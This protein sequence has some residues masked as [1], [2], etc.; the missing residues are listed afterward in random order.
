MPSFQMKLSVLIGCCLVWPFTQVGVA[1]PPDTV[2]REAAFR[3]TFAQVV[4]MV[5]KGDYAQA[6]P[7]LHRLRITVAQP[8]WPEIEGLAAQLAL[9]AGGT[10]RAGELIQPFAEKLKLQQ[11]DPRTY[12][13]LY[14]RGQLAIAV[15]NPWE[16]VGIFDFLV[17]NTTGEDHVFAAKGAAEAFVAMKNIPEARKALD[18][19]INHAQRKL[20]RAGSEDGGGDQSVNNDYDWLIDL[21]RRQRKEL[22][23]PKKQTK[24]EA[25]VLFEKAEKLRRIDAKYK[26]AHDVYQ[27]IINA[28][29]DTTYAQASKLFAIECSLL[30]GIATEMI[31]KE[32]VAFVEQDRYGLYTGEALLML[33]RIALERRMDAKLAFKYFSQLDDWLTAAPKQERP[34]RVPGDDRKHVTPTKQEFTID[35]WGNLSPPVIK[36]G[37]LVN[38]ATADW[39]MRDLESRSVRYLGFVYMTNKS[40]T[41]AAAAFKRL[42]ALDPATRELED[43]GEAS[44]YT[45]LMFGARHG[46]LIA[47]PQELDLY[48]DSRKYAI[49]LGDFYYVTQRFDQAIAMYQ[50]LLNGDFGKLTDRQR[51][52]PWLAQGLAY[53]RVGKADEALKMFRKV[54]E[55]KDNTFSELRAAAIAGT[56]AIWAKDEKL[57]AEG[58]AWLELAMTTGGK[59]HFAYEAAVTLGRFEIIRGNREKGL[60][61]L[62][63][64]PVSAGS[65]YHIADFLYKMHAGQPLPHFQKE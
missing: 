57:A 12:H 38:R 21:L 45:R 29:P 47:Y 20:K 13:L 28:A 55:R 49:F 25:L 31:E 11:Y 8:R 4:R 54:L 2:E 62:R 10:K 48:D 34:L 41:K 16:A 64:I 9:E 1:V 35:F 15:E 6:T 65:W 59:S 44:D 30:T 46:Y 61:I 17:K 63:Q 39:A 18:Y 43:R 7:L 58:R 56:I 22:D 50:R 60:T 32:I 52:Y 26:Q 27:Q 37:Q 53:Q 19:A 42:L 5:R 33:G 23:A 40:P 36:P 51:D 3:R 24:S 14:A